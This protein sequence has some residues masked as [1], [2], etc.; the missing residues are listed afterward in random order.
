MTA[1]SEVYITPEELAAMDDSQT[2]DFWHKNQSSVV[3]IHRVQSL[4]MDYF[5]SISDGAFILM[6]GFKRIGQYLRELDLGVA[7]DFIQN[8]GFGQIFQYAPHL[9]RFSVV[10]SIPATTRQKVWCSSE[11]CY[12]GGERAT[13]LHSDQTTMTDWKCKDALKYLKIVLQYKDATPRILSS[14]LQDFS[15]GDS[16]AKSYLREQQQKKHQFYSQ[17][18]RLQFLE[19]L[20]LGYDVSLIVHGMASLRHYLPF[21]ATQEEIKD[22]NQKEQKRAQELV[23]D[24]F[25]LLMG[26]S[27][28]THLAQ[29]RR[30]SLVGDFWSLMGQAEVEFIHIHWRS[31]ESIE[32]SIEDEDVFYKVVRCAHWVWLKQHRPNLQFYALFMSRRN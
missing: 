5:P 26:L 24:D 18:N 12:S 25:T 14:F 4:C 15:T 1:V 19:E 32:F 6:T 23:L 30:L 13:M 11:G 8:H 9:R 10:D 17:V 31:L 21:R 27:K 22:M 7:N 29:L 28:L 3:F 20:T 16:K 2:A